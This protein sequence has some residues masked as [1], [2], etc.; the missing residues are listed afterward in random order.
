MLRVIAPPGDGTRVLFRSR[1]HDMA[2]APRPELLDGMAPAQHSIYRE[3][4]IASME[5]HAQRS[6]IG[7]KERSAKRG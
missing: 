2:V 3:Q 7:A 5:A 4:E 6:L 1:R